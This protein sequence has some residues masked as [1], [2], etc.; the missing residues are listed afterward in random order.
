MAGHESPRTTKLYDRTK[1]EVTL[2]EVGRI[3][4]RPILK[5]R[6]HGPKFVDQSVKEELNQLNSNQTSSRR[7]LDSARLLFWIRKFIEPLRLGSVAERA[8]FVMKG[9]SKKTVVVA[10]PFKHL[11][12]NA[13]C[14][15]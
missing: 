8:A 7:W 1:D 2:R 12:R 3:R 15:P 9:S 6:W 10:R 4:L 5:L 14:I 13:E 11:L